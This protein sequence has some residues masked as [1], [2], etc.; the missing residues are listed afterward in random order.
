MKIAGEDK[1]DTK[2]LTSETLASFYDGGLF[3]RLADEQGPF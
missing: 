1:G 2:V 3:Y